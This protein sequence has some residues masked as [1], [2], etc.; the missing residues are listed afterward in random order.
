MN[1]GRRDARTRLAHLLCEVATRLQ[2]Q[3]L[4]NDYG[5]ELPMTQEQLA[6]ATALTNVHV[7]RTLKSLEDEG[8]I[9]RDR[10]AIRFPNWQALKAAAGFDPLYLHLGQQSAAGLG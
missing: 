2:G 8:L 9:K 3:D 7:N 4:V 6:D 5:Y 10:R 1:V